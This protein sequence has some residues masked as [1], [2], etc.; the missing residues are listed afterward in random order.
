LVLDCLTLDLPYFGLRNPKVTM[1]EFPTV[2][3]YAELQQA[4]EH[5][6]Q[7]LFDGQLPQCLITFQREKSTY[8]YF[9][10]RRFVHREGVTL[11]DEIALNPAYFA[12][13]PMVEIFQTLVHE[14]VHSWQHHFG[15]P[16]RRRYHNAQ[17][18]SKMEEVGLVPSS[19]GKAGGAKTGEKMADY[20]L[21][22]GRFLKSC[23]D[24]VEGKF[25]ISWL[26]RFPPQLPEGGGGLRSPSVMD[27]AI[28]ALIELHPMLEKP[29]GLGKSNRV[30]QRCP[31][32]GAQAW[33]K[34]DLKLRCGETECARAR[35]EPVTENS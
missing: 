8:G 17:W 13:V 3:A 2:Q 16:G 6:N 22:G 25:S 24:L 11:T 31:N 18:A 21:T 9:S 33:G 4:F 14:M 23:D 20:P 5:F 26:D 28:A 32:C 34:P 12:V 1:S 19:T 10:A 35:F 30:K 7:S 29:T 27:P 15:A